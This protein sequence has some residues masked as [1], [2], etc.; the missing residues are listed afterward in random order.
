MSGRIDDL[1]VRLEQALEENASG[2]AVVALS[3][4]LTNDSGTSLVL[5][6]SGPFGQPEQALA[7]AGRM[8]RDWRGQ[9]SSEAEAAAI[10][11]LVVPL[12]PAGD[13]A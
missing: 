1:I 6:V 4:D 11:Y 7:E 3:K 12:W 13:S 5:N 10:D 2:F 8:D 9:A